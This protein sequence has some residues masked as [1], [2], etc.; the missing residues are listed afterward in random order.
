MVTSGFGSRTHPIYGGERLHAG[1]D[2]RAPTGTPIRA[3]A[4][5]VVVYAGWRGGYGNAVIIDHGGSLATLSG[6][7]SGIN[8]ATGQAVATGQVIGA[9][10]STGGSTGPH[11][12]FEVR[13]DGVPVDPWTHL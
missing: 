7:L 4:D 11:L 2:F 13:V 1:I 5:G 12:H 9:A 8:V 3:A 6:H 10:G